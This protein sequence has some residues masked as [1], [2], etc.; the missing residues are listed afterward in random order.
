MY[1]IYN[2]ILKDYQHNYFKRIFT[3]N[4][5]KRSFISRIYITV[6]LTAGIITK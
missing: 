3:I 2:A 6:R 5:L 4:R 1:K